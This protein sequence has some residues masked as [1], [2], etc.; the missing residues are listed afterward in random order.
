MRLIVAYCLEHVPNLRNFRIHL[1]LQNFYDP[2]FRD[3]SAFSRTLCSYR[4]T[5]FGPQY[6]LW[7]ARDPEHTCVHVHT[8]T[9]KFINVK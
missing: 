4:V 8:Y 6:A 1:N 7:L 9:F 3:C 2:D 5:G